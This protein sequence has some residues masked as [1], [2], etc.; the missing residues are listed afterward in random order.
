MHPGEQFFVPGHSTSVVALLTH[1]QI[2]I[3]DV[4]KIWV[5]IIAAQVGSDDQP[6]AILGV[7]HD[8]EVTPLTLVGA[9]RY[10][11]GTEHE[12]RPSHHQ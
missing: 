4:T 2:D 10:S 9:P 3:R 6:G 7:P 1:A 5:V 8:A 11:M 12:N